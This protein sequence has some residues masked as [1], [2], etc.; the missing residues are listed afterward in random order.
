[1]L[2]WMVLACV[3]ACAD[4]TTVQDDTGQDGHAP[5]IDNDGDG[6]LSDV[7]CDDY[8][9]AVFP[10][11]IEV[12]DGVD[13]DCDGVVDDGVSATWY[14]DTDSDGYGD[15][16]NTTTACSRPDGYVPVPSDCDDTNADAWPGASEDCNGAD[17]DCD[18][19]IDEGVTGQFYADTDFDGY[20]DPFTLVESCQGL[21]GVSDDPTD[22]DDGDPD[23]FPGAPEHCNGAD[24]DCDALVDEEPTVEGGSWW[25]DADGDGYGDPGGATASTCIGPAGYTDNTDDCDD[26]DRDVSP[27]APEVCSNDIDDDCDGDIDEGCP[28]EHCGTITAD[29]TWEGDVAHIVTCDVIVG[30]S[31]H[32]I[33]TVDDGAIV[34]FNSGTG[35][36]VGTRSY[37]S[38]VIAG[39]RLGVTLTSSAAAPAAGDWYGVE[40]GYYDEGSLLSGFSLRYGGGEGYG[41][42]LAYGSEPSLS[43]CTLA[44]NAGA[45]LYG[46]LGAA[47]NVTGC[48][49]TDNEDDGVTL[50]SSSALGAFSENTLSGNGGYPLTTP[51]ISLA[52]LDADSTYSGN[53]DDRIQVTADQITASGTWRALSVPYYVVGDLEIEGSSTPTITVEDGAAFEFAAGVG[54]SSGLSSKGILD[55]RGDI[56]GVIF[57]AAARDPGPGDWDGLSF[58][59]FDQGSNLTGATVMHGGGNGYGGVYLNSADLDVSECT[60][61]LNEG[62]GLYARNGAAPDISDSAL[63]DNDGYGLYIASDATLAGTTSA[64]FTVNTVSG[65]SEEGVVL[66]AVA[67]GLLDD[68]ST[69]TG[70][71]EPGVRVLA[72]TIE[73]DA[74]WAALDEPL[75]LSGD[76]LVEDTARP[77]LT[78]KAGLTVQFDPGAA[79]L[80]GV[81]GHG[82]LSAAGTSR[83]GI[84]LTSSDPDPAPGDWEGLTLGERCDASDVKLT[85]VTVSYGGANGLGNVVFDQCDGTMTKSTVSGSDAYGIYRI[86][87]SPTLTDITYADNAAGTLY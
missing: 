15:P 58:G 40:I 63:T 36:Y 72:G 6:Y 8:S 32:P 31:G 30:G 16:Q 24:D 50:E 70:N 1:M 14:A 61:T 35:L 39:D 71:G 26:R 52:S 59:P 41:G 23:V 21:P 45:G 66:A 49:I 34:T 86:D 67:V 81:T 48:E 29:E 54:L 82:A 42:L 51:G 20:G 69:Y 9:S 17:D 28:V 7:D 5:I 57:R 60:I 43:E 22:C 78:L 18:G 11:A 84:T 64:S 55:V 74:T 33:L 79:L 10:D 13:N 44:D 73:D 75:I 80:I 19:E 53:G 38:L 87:A 47:P 12:C 56:E 37:G 62:A 27:A 85:Y 77:I 65:N 76:V 68:S 4:K 25:P 2:R 3:C 83:S 46:R